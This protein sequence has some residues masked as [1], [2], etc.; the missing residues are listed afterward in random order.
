MRV[1]WWNEDSD[2]DLDLRVIM[3]N[4]ECFD[5]HLKSC[6]ISILLPFFRRNLRLL[7]FQLKV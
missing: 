1:S 2:I 7:L 6:E 4:I 3:F 5:F